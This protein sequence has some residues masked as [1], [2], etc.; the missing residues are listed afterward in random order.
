MILYRTK[1]ASESAI[2]STSMTLNNS[3]NKKT[4][5][6]CKRTAPGFGTSPEASA[7][8]LHHVIICRL[9]IK[10]KTLE[11]SGTLRPEQRARC[12]IHL[13]PPPTYRTRKV[14][15]PLRDQG[16]GIQKRIGFGNV[17]KLQPDPLTECIPFNMRT[18]QQ[19]VML[20]ECYLG[21][22]LVRAAS[23]CSLAQR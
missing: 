6:Q 8:G 1:P 15:G 10:P 2:M 4:L 18:Q 5:R 9:P 22:S 11:P 16:F 23:G 19:A 20:R 7:E 3:H 14:P 12:L 21:W 17:Q 13:P